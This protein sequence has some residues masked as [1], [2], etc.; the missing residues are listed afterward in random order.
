MI[1]FPFK[2]VLT[3]RGSCFTA[4]GFEKACRNLGIDHRKTKPYTPKTNGRIGREVLTI[5]IATHHDLECLLRVRGYNVAYNARRQRPLRGK[6]PDEAVRDRLSAKPELANQLYQPST[7]PCI[8][9]KAMAVVE[10]AK[11][12]SHPDNLTGPCPLCLGHDQDRM[13]GR[14][15]GGNPRHLSTITVVRL[16][17]R[18]MEIGRNRCQV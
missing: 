5:T 13:Q 15:A 18:P 12:I 11:D 10:S 16:S 9:P 8:L 7:D 4:D 2:V 3:D 14:R 6:S 1:A 17:L